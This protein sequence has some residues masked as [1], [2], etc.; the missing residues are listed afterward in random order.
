MTDSQSDCIFC[1]IASGAL[2]VPFVHESEHTVAFK[3]QAPLAKEHILI[4]PKRHVGSLT[5]IT[6]DDDSL[7]GELMETARIVAEKQGMSET[8]YRVVT[9]VGPDAGQTVFHLHLHVLGGESLG[10]FGRE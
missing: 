9:N 10:Q 3:D 2:G 4:V 5:E 8:G 6:R 1:K 7:L